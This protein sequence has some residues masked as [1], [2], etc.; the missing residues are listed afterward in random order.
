M[1]CNK[2]QII[3]ELKTLSENNYVSVQHVNG[4]KKKKSSTND[5]PAEVQMHT[6]ADE[7]CKRVRN[8]RDQTNYHKMPANEVNFVLNEETINANATKATTIA[9]NSIS[10]REY[11]KEKYKWTDQQVNDV[12]WKVHHRLMSK[13]ASHDLIR[14]K[15]FIFNLL[16]T[17]RKLHIRNGSHKEYCRNCHTEIENENHILRCKSNLRQ[18]V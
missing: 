17:N 18:K 1:R 14:T 8:L 4:H 5:V 12:W 15:K 2:L 3:E 10:L 11:M 9:Y 13:L 6:M 7:L 16:P